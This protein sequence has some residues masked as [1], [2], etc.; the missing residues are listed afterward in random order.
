MTLGRRIA[1]L[2]STLFRS[3]RLDAD[4]D[5]ELQAYLRAAT[6]RRIRD[7]L[8][9]DAARREAEREMGPL[10]GI[11][12]E[13]RRARVGVGVESALR[14]A[15]LAVRGLRRSPAFAAATVATLALGIGANTAIFS[16]VDAM[17]I[18]P[19]P[20]R[21]SGRLVFVWSDMTREGYPRAPLSGPELDDLR[22][23]ATGFSGFGAIW[24]NTATLSGDAEPEQVRV[25]FVTGDFF[26][27]LGAGASR[28]RTVRDGDDEGE[29]S[30]LLSDALWQRRFGGD[31]AI[32]GRRILV[33][34]EP[35]TVVGVMP[36]SFRLL[37]PP[38][39]AVPDDLEAWTP[40]W[41][42]MT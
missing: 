10:D 2:W 18:A 8:D 16:V 7:G 3:R 32:V 40:F 4:L 9:P 33:N 6:E 28:G 35:T 11:R 25:G 23:R 36:P 38:D 12:E 15:R 14:D 42:K 29:P 27:V 17:L 1:G 13:T 30:I 37:L 19:L 24:A 41:P 22:R 26:P 34:G 5:D 20:Y 31:P 21:D 39:S